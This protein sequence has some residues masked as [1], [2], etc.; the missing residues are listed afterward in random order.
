MSFDQKAFQSALKLGLGAWELEEF[1][2]LLPAFT[3]F[4]EL[5]IETNQTLNLT[6]IVEPEE[7]A[8]K[9]FLDSLALL[10]LDWPLQVNCLDLGTGAGFPG[11]PLAMARPEWSLTL[12]DSLRKR[13]RFLERAAQEQG[14]GNL[15]TLHARA[16][17][18]G[19]DKRHR[20]TYDLVVSR[21][22]AHLPVLLELATPLVK[23]GGYFVAYKGSEARAERKESSQALNKLNV[24]L[25]RV[26]DLNLPLDMGART[27]LVFRKLGPTPPSYPRK[28]GIPGKLPL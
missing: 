15:T 22:V 5:V 8:I 27:L 11:V 13:L 1:A 21:A 19:Q 28:A 4:A 25:E 16:E 9:N 26:F 17:D 18:A 2:D 20:Q 10:R 7:M 6:R 14:L 12:L 3:N 23:V 24:E